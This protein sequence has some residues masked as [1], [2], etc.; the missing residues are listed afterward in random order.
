[1]VRLNGVRLPV[2]VLIAEAREVGDGRAAVRAVH[3]LAASTP[4]ELRRL[5]RIGQRL[6]GAPECLD[7]D[8]VV[9][10][11]GFGLSHGG[12]FRSVCDGGMSPLTPLSGMAV[13]RS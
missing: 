4:L 5:G 13:C 6:P 7:V 1:M 10:G 3:P 2:G 9:D 11:G 8:T 12:S